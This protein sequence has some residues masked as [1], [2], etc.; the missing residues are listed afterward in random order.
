MVRGTALMARRTGHWLALVVL[1]SATPG[2]VAE[3]PALPAPAANNAV[4]A[5]PAGPGK[6][7]FSFLGLGPG[8]TWQDIRRDAWWLPGDAEQWRALPPVPGG[9]GRLAP[10]AVAVD[11]AIYLFGG[12]T[13]AA[14]H[15]ETSTP[16]VYR[17]D[18]E[19][20]PVYTEVAPMPVPVDDAVAL[21]YRDRYVYLVS[22]WHD[23]GNVNLVQ[24]YDVR[25]DRWVQATP[26]PG[27]PVFGHAGGIVGERMLVCGG[28]RIRQRPD[29]GREFVLNEACW[30]GEIDPDRPRRIAWREIEPAT[31]AARYR[32]AARGVDIYGERV[33]FAGGTRN[34]YNYNGIGYNGAPAA[35]IAPIVGFNLE[36]LSWQCHGEL[37]PP[38][39]DHR[40]LLQVRGG[41]FALIGGMHAD[42]QVTA[43][44][45]RFRLAEPRPCGSNGP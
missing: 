17:V 25:T 45:N 34:P 22:G 37:D 43:A 12:Y 19:G 18:P 42:Q 15:S 1:L 5:L 29:G 20:E 30:L 27:A 41:E 14:D 23:V 39:M 24:R 6:A 38:S 2:V 35:P 40:G 21:V 13:V 26:Y 3:P 10:V 36:Q 31:P 11:G 44:V 32:A 9:R 28:A 16:E 7:L 4:A 33:V 8:K